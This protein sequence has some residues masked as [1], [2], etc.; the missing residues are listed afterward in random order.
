MRTV[1][2]EGIEAEPRQMR[3]RDPETGQN[4]LVNE[5]TYDEWQKWVIKRGG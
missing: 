3:A 4:V 2:K 1:E 5:M